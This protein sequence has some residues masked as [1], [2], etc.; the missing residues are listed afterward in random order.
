MYTYTQV[1]NWKA[2]RR[3]DCICFGVEGTECSSCKVSVCVNRFHSVTTSLS[4]QEPAVFAYDAAVTDA[5]I[6]EFRDAKVDILVSGARKEHRDDK[7]ETSARSLA[8]YI[9]S[10]RIKVEC[11]IGMVKGEFQVLENKL[12]SWWVPQLHMISFNCCCLHNFRF[13]VLNK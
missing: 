8:Q 7:L 1:F 12:P 10:E 6:G 4:L 3:L 9:S 2:Y 13:R 11:V 5:V